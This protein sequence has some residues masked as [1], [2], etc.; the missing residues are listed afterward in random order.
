MQPF[1]PITFLLS[2]AA[3]KQLP[4]DTGKEIAFAG[5]SNAGKSSA[6][7]LITGNKKLART[8]KTPGC[9][10]LINFF[11]IDEQR[12]LVDLPGY[13][14]AKVAEH[15]KERWQNTLAQYLETRRA[16]CGLIL[17]MDI[18]HPLKEFDKKMLHW[19]VSQQLPVHILLSKT[20]KISRN[21]AQKTLQQVQLALTH[22][23]NKISVQLFSAH[24]GLGLEQIRKHLLTWLDYQ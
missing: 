13:G 18:R 16:L 8:S 10:Q 7:N 21:T 3:L 2:V 20:D 15:I 23:P 17:V 5:R 24:S 22:L 4:K 14:Y 11:R 6:I 9:T 19:S 1:P 12:H